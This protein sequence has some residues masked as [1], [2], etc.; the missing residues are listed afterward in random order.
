[1]NSNNII[2]SYDFLFP[3]GTD[4][5]NTYLKKK[6]RVIKELSMLHRKKL[7]ILIP[8]LLLIPML[9]GMISLKMEHKLSHYSYNNHSSHSLI[10]DTD[11]DVVTVDSLSSNQGLPYL[12][13]ILP[14]APVFIHSHQY[15]N[16]I[17]LRC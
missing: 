6:Y 12:Q 16:S 5:A 2:N 10:F 4:L 13:E 1:M 11:V 8:S 14:M 3:Y 15:F 7:L 17:P 9:L